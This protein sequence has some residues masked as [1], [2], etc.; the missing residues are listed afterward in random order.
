MPGMAP[1]SPVALPPRFVAARRTRLVGRRYELGVLETVWERA[2]QGPARSCWSA[3]SPA[4]ARPGWPPRPPARCT[5]R[6][7]R[8]WWARRRRT[9]ACPYQP[10]V[11]MLDHLLLAQRARHADRRS[12]T[13]R[14][15]AGCRAHAA[16]HRRAVARSRSSDGVRRDLFEAVAELFRSMAR[17]RPLVVVLDD[18]HWAQLP[19]IALLEHVVHSCLDAPI[20]GGGD[21]PHHRAGPVGRPQR[22]HGRPA[23][24]RR[25]APPR[26]GRPRHRGHRAS[27]CAEHADVS[28]AGAR[29]SAAILRDRTGGNP[30][31]L[32]ETWLDLERT[33]R[34][35]GAARPA[36]GTGLPRRHPARPGWRGSATAVREIIELAA[37]IGDEF[38]LPTLVAGRRGRPRPRAWTRSTRPSRSAC[39]NPSRR[40]AG[41]LRVR[42]LA[43]PAGRRS[44]G[45]RTPAARALH[46]RVAQALEALARDPALT[47]RIAHHYLAAHLLGYHDQALHYASTAARQAVHSLAFEEAACGSTGRRRCRTTAENVRARAVVRRRGEPPA[48]G[49]LRPGPGHLRAAGR[50]RPTR[51]CGC[52]AA[53]GLEEAVARP[54]LPDSRAADLLSLGPRRLRPRPG[55]PAVRARARQ[56]R[57]GPGVRRPVDEARRGGQP[58]DRGRAAAAA[59]GRRLVHALRTSLWHGLTPDVAATQLARATEL[60]RLCTDTGDR[61]P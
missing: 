57:P 51:W 10:F 27:S 35:R 22:P 33:R 56:P 28:P 14:A 11:E 18:L 54:G 58:G 25:R 21:L 4:R 52:E 3:A 43:D 39:S 20:A 40:T 48:R 26:P 12:P 23:P 60:A 42:P 32:R 6:A 19:T 45:C 30:F 7:P 55:R 44:T 17:D 36:A 8:C 37:V 61:E 31:F 15:A 13:A 50:R 46:A 47:P 41:P 9:P 2:A 16:R 38:D 5:T 59:T 53:M 34:C 29:A 1:W 49:R 24:A